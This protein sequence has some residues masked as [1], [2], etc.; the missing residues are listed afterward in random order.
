VNYNGS[1]VARIRVDAGLTQKVAAQRIGRRMKRRTLSA[2]YLMHVE[3]G[4]ERP[5]IE[6]VRAMATEYKRPVGVVKQALVLER[7]AFLAGL[8]EADRAAG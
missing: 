3:R 8:K 5:S 6:L 4:R 2:K 1:R 7:R